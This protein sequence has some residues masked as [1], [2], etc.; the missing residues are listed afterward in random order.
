MISTRYIQAN[1]PKVE[2]YNPQLLN[3]YTLYLDANN[4]YGCGMCQSLAYGGFEWISTDN[5]SKEWILSMEDD[6]HIFEI[7]LEDSSHLHDLHNEYPVALEKLTVT[8]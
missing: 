2:N 3:S 5:I 8:Q 4:I 6:G 7:N 1:N